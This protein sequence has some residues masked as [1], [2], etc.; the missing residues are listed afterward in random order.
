MVSERKDFV[1]QPVSAQCQWARSILYKHA[2]MISANTEF[3]VN[4][5]Q[6]LHPDSRVIWQPNEQHL[7][8]ELN[9][10]EKLCKTF[11]S[12]LDFIPKKTLTSSLEPRPCFGNS[13][14]LRSISSGKAPTNVDS[15]RWLLIWVLTRKFTSG[16]TSQV[17]RFLGAV[18]I[19]GCS[20]Q[21]PATKGPVTRCMSK[22]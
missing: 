6:D 19:L 8:L 22:L 16:V 7:S 11:T 3:T 20:S 2:D 14:F 4:Q 13:V 12:L 1:R 10:P 15:R 5:I 17:P 9:R 21:T 18:Y